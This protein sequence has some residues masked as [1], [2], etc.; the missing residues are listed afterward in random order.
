MKL[1]HSTPAGSRRTARR[2]RSGPIAIT[3]L[4][5]AIGLAGCAGTTAAPVSGQP[6]GDSAPLTLTVAQAASQINNAPVYLAQTLGY[7]EEE[8]LDITILDATGANTTTL[9]A[10]GQADLGDLGPGGA[11]LMTKQGR[12]TTIIYQQL[13]A[14]A[15]AYVFAKPD[16]QSI[17]EVRG[18]RFG[19]F[20]V[21]SGTY[22]VA[23]V[24]STRQ[25]L[26]FDLVPL[27]NSS[28]ISAAIVSDQ[29][30][31]GNG[32]YSDFANDV[33]SGKLHLLIDANDA[34]QREKYVGDP[35]PA[36]VT[37]GLVDTV[38]KK[39]DAIVAFLHA[40]NRALEWMQESTPEQVATELRK[41]AAYATIDE[42]ALIVAIERGLEFVSPDQGRISDSTW[43]Y[44]LTQYAVWGLDGFDASDPMYGYEE[45]VD[46]SLLDEALAE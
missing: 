46:M 24:L 18:Q 44:A 33:E 4:A 31:A 40:R 2:A 1:F 22:G 39:S 27:Q 26:D 37:F 28:A 36:G 15:G 19:T 25:G 41:S 8:G 7:Y 29:V 45:R 20:S 5:A 35:Y 42:K 6:S 13:D 3:A 23:N 12:P 10:S 30:A 34:A 16:V 43:E 14:G 32:N 11:L 38:D 21:G 17:D 9:V